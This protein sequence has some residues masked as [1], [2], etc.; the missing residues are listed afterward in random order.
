MQLHFSYV[1]VLYLVE[2][3]QRHGDGPQCLLYL[4]Q[5]LP[6]LQAELLPPLQHPNLHRDL[7][8]VPHRLLRLVLV[9]GLK[10]IGLI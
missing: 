3:D 5:A 4:D 6:L 9:V 10:Q 1:H 7:D 2:A 8:D